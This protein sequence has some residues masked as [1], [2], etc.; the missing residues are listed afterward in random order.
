M[1]YHDPRGIATLH[2][3]IFRIEYERSSSQLPMKKSSRKQFSGKKRSTERCQDLERSSKESEFEASLA[4][5]RRILASEAQA[6][7]EKESKSIRLGEHESSEKTLSINSMP[8]FHYDKATDRFYKVA[9][10]TP[11]YSASKELS[12]QSVSATVTNDAFA[13]DK[14]SIVTTLFSRQCGRSTE[15]RRVLQ[16]ISVSQLKLTSIP[17]DNIRDISFHKTFGVICS[18]ASSIIMPTQSGANLAMNMKSQ[19][20]LSAHQE[21]EVVSWH[22]STDFCL[23]GLSTSVGR[24][25]EIFVM[26][27]SDTHSREGAVNALQT[28]SVS[29]VPFEKTKIWS[30]CWNYCDESLIIG[31]ESNLTWLHLSSN[32]G[33]N[34]KSVIYSSNSPIMTIHHGT[35]SVGTGLIFIGHRNGA[36][37]MIDPRIRQLGAAVEPFSCLPFCVDHLRPLQDGV[38][39]VAQDITGQISVFDARKP[40]MEYLRVIDG[41]K[42][43]CSRRFWLSADEK[44]VVAS[45]PSVSATGLGVFS[46][47]ATSAGTLT[48]VAPYPWL[49]CATTEASSGLERTALDR[50]QYPIPNETKSSSSSSMYRQKLPSPSVKLAPNCYEGQLCDHNRT[51]CNPWDGLFGI[52]NNLT[53]QECTHA[54]IRASQSRAPLSSCLITATRDTLIRQIF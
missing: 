16:D 38:S 2:F 19:G 28:P 46:L 8:G 37:K 33:R 44:S 10:P 22:P 32:S 34:Q 25:A 6:D 47:R 40:S 54:A 5:Q 12:R 23:L 9:D 51:D 35:R 7:C 21:L 43:V 26:R 13:Y 15:F 27:S 52:V 42:I 4:L 11:H 24:R 1:Y 48:K 29:R 18:T 17:C 39:V 31:S 45:H 53:G 49:V 3:F 20:I 30:M 41:T 14:F 36:I 50:A